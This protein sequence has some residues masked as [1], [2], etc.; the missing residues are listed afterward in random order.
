MKKIIKKIVLKIKYMYYINR[1]YKAKIKDN[2]VLIES[3]NSEDLASNMFYIV[4]ELNKKEYSDLN[5]YISVKKNKVDKIVK[6]LKTY[7]I[8]NYILVTSMSFKYL[9]ILASAKYLFNDTSF[10]KIFIKKEGQVYTNTWHGTPLKCMSNDVPE[11]RYAMGNVKRNFLMA[12]YLIYPNSEMEEKMLSAYSIN[13]LFQG[14]IINGGYPRN[15]IFFDKK[16]ASFI[17]EQLG[18]KI[19]KF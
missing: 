9:N 7:D 5:V 19:N 12:D 2:Y 1:Y 14:Q 17:K 18:L 16:R 4:K 10:P 13:E 3:K 15:S 11:R 8:N 6:L